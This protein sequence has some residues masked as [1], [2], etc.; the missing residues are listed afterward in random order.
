MERQR[1]DVDMKRLGPAS[2]RGDP[3]PAARRFPTETR[4]LTLDQTAVE[5]HQLP[6][7]RDMENRAPWLRFLDMLPLSSPIP[8]FDR[9]VDTRRFLDFV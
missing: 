6:L 4:L 1:F 3:G 5:R 8:V 9:L 2:R 7:A